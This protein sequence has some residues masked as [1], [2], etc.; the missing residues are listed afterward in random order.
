V[1]LVAQVLKHE[2]RLGPSLD[3]QWIRS[4]REVHLLEPLRQPDRRDVD[5]G[6]GERLGGR[7][8]L[9]APPVHDDQRGRVGEAPA[10]PWFAVAVP[11][12]TREPAREHLLHAG[13][14]V[15]P[16]HAFDLEP[17]VVGPLG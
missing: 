2:Q 6:L 10:F 12:Q 3:Q 17:P 14:V 8:E 9:A 16:R 7:G 13:E 1:G 5:V 4:L 15:L 11:S